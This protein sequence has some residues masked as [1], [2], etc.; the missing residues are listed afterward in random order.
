[1]YQSSNKQHLSMIHFTVNSRNFVTVII[2]SNEHFFHILL[3][4]RSTAYKFVKYELFRTLVFCVLFSLF[5]QPEFSWVHQSQKFCCLLC[6]HM[7]W[8]IAC[9]FNTLSVYTLRLLWFA[10]TIWTYLFTRFERNWCD[11][12]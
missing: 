5:G 4:S 9:I 8:K 2:L 3:G 6:S 7:F 12:I 10:L 1:M 11:G